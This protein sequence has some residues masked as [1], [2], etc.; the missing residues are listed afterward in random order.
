MSQEGNSWKSSLRVAA[1]TDVGLRRANNQ[2]SHAIALATSLQNLKKRGHLFVVADGMGAHAAGELASRIAT[3]TITLSYSKR[4]SESVADALQN[5]VYDAHHQIRTQGERDE[6]F[7][8]MGTTVDALVIAPGGAV[9]AHVGDSRVYRL[10]NRVFEQLTFDHSLVWEVRAS[11]KIPHDKIPNF[12]PKNV[13]TRSL[14]PSENLKVDLEGPFYV[15]VGDYFLLCSDGLSGQV[16]DEEIGQILFVLPP[17]FATEILINLANLR[18]GP[19]NITAVA[20]QVV[21]PLDA[22]SPHPPFHQ[23]KAISGKTFSLLAWICL[24]FAMLGLLLSGY[25]LVTD[26]QSSIPTI[27]SAVITLFFGGGFFLLSMRAEPADPDEDAETSAAPFGKGPYVRVDATSNPAF[28]SKLATT[29]HQLRDAA[30]G[31]QWEIHWTEIDHHESLATDAA[32]AGN[33]TQAIYHY[34]LTINRMMSELKSQKR[35]KN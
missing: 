35:R 4:L 20:V 8:D 10:R 22:S 15:K 24:A 6:A 1:R 28:V 17:E 7:H 31:E 19:D 2:D 12:I 9:I 30:Q 27:V 21:T 14:G 29:V 34:A 11:G 16:E 5:S 32:N 33:F 23:E 26:S 3:D 25:S 18:G 13:I